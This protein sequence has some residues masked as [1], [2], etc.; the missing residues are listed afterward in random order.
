MSTAHLGSRAQAQRV[1][2]P[3]SITAAD[4]RWQH[5]DRTE[6]AISRLNFHIPAGQKVLLLGPSGAG[7]STLLHAMAGVLQIDEQTQSSGS[8]SLGEQDAFAHTATIGLMQQ[9]PETQ[10]VQSKIGDDVAFGAENL[11]VAA[12]QIRER[13]PPALTAVGLGHLNLEHPTGQLSGGQK[14]R[15]ALAG[16]LAMRPSVMLLDEPT[17]NIDPQGAADLRGAILDAVATSGATL[18]V[19]EH[20]VEQ[21]IDDM[22]RVLVLE[23]GG[24]I[25]HDLEPRALRENTSVR[26]EL[27]AAG[28]WIPDY[29]PATT[30]VAARPGKLLLHTQAL[31]ARH[32]VTAPTGEPVDLRIHAGTATVIRGGNGVGKTALA[33]TLGGLLEPAHGTLFASE[34]LAAG[35]GE[36][37]F[38]WKAGELVARIGSV[39]QEP[40]HQFVAQTVAEELAY[41]PRRAQRTGPTESLS[42]QNIQARTTQLLA[43]LGLEHLAE[44][45]PYT[46]SG[47]EKRRLS[48]A[49]VLAARPDVLILDEPTFG[50][51]ANTWRE[52]V[53]LLGEVLSEG[54]AVIAVTHDED[55]AHALGAT[56][57]SLSAP[58]SSEVLAEA[59]SGLPEVETESWLGRRNPLAKLAAVLALTIPLIA[60]IDPISGAVVI[61]ATLAM[62]PL[63]K[64]SIIGFFKRAWP[65]L[66]AGALAGWGIALVGEDSGR[67]LIS[68][69]AL[70]ITEGSVAG[71]IATGMRAIALAVPMVLV[72]ST[73]SP[74]DLGSALSQQLRVPHRFVLGA[75]AGMRLLGLMLEEFTTL[76]LAR[77]AR[78]VGNFGSPL[79]RVKAN[80]GQVLALLVQAIRRAGRLAITMEAKGF[81]VGE[82]TWLHRPGFTWRDGLVI[83]SGVIVGVLAIVLALWTGS[84]NLVWT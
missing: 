8:L 13:I 44:A 84:W 82:R 64:L 43:R 71:G 10:I 79:Q 9:D 57:L 83:A 20:R 63:A 54:T 42:E 26:A 1:T 12:E 50:Q 51:D 72:L 77:R 16:I 73:T 47:G 24:G 37:P 17:A 52:L 15:L 18:V 4:F 34:E 14:Q 30:A 69:G 49:T 53:E 55:F 22:D 46:L 65:L 48:V 31:R 66:I 38:R 60:T 59:G 28:I 3:L 2:Q 39:F 81:G 36:H 80:F 58:Q 70:D 61:L 56:Q 74:S 45:N 62:L 27:A 67:V 33:L 68:L 29:L 40:E 35:A 19:V 32:S 41:G 11:G 21:W 7:K 78:G 75:L 6:P 25:A 5:A 76:K 23:P